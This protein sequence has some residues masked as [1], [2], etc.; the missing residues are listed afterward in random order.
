MPQDGGTTMGTA[1]TST[2]LVSA[3]GISRG[4]SSSSGSSSSSG[5][6]GGINSSSGGA[7]S[8]V[9]TGLT[10]YVKGRARDRGEREGGRVVFVRVQCHQFSF[11][12][13][14][15]CVGHE[16]NVSVSLLLMLP[17]CLSSCI[18]HPLPHLQSH[19]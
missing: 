10:R 9:S 14:C 19:I 1:E 15:V 5:G 2:A 7:G 13:S 11:R 8:L 18:I 4:R 17:F 12:H 16:P 6:N 3:S